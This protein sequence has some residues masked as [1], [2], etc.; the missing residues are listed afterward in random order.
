[1]N[2]SEIT[3]RYPKIKY[4]DTTVYDTTLCGVVKIPHDEIK[5][6]NLIIMDPKQ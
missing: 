6:I 1:M 4:I 2:Y 5:S 3:A